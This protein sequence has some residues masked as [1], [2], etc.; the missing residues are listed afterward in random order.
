MVRAGTI[1][2]FDVTGQAGGWFAPEPGDVRAGV[3]DALHPYLTVHNLTLTKTSGWRDIDFFWWNYSAR[4]DVQTKSDHARVDDVASIVAHAFY[5]GAGTLPT[6]TL[7]A[8]TQAP[9][10]VQPPGFVDSTLAGLQW[11]AVLLVGGVVVVAYFLSK[12]NI[13]LSAV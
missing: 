13:K 1:L 2:T 10:V 7:G 5:V 4:V 12:S 8:G 11:T 9:A 6:V 3:I